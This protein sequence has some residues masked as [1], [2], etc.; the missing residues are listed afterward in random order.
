MQ[1]GSADIG[2]AQQQVGR[3]IIEDGLVE[4]GD[5]SGFF[6]QPA[7]RSRRL[8]DQDGQG[9][10]GLAHLRLEFRDAAEGAQVLGLGLLQIELI[11]VAAGEQPFGDFKTALL[12]LGVLAGDAQTR[13]GGAQGEIGFGNLCAQEHQ[14]VLVVGLSGE[15]G[16][17]GRFYGAAEPP[18]KSSSQ[19]TSKPA[20][21]C[22][23]LLSCGLR[24]PD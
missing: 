8:A 5:Q 19:P 9:I 22:Q 24:P 18:Q 15:E 17:V 6:L 12:P 23:R 1:F 20:L 10:A 4:Q 16:R 7:Q 2:A 21:Y 14:Q 11:A 3:H 13:F